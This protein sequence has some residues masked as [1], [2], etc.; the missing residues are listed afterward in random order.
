MIISS[1]EAL[2][3]KEVDG[4]IIDAADVFLRLDVL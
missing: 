1:L 2:I 3:A 4:G